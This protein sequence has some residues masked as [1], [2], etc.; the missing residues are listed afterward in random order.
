MPRKARVDA[1]G[2]LHHIIVRGIER[3]K[4]FRIDSDRDDFLNRFGKLIAETKSRCF[5]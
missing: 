4:I 3:A 5:A 1:P 2:A